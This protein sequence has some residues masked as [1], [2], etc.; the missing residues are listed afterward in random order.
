MCPFLLQDVNFSRLMDGWSCQC[1]WHFWY[2]PGRALEWFRFQKSQTCELPLLIPPVDSAGQQEP[3]SDHQRLPA[4]PKLTGLLLI[5]KVDNSHSVQL[6][7]FYGI[8]EKV[9][10]RPWGDSFARI[11]THCSQNCHQHHETLLDFLFVLRKERLG[12]F[13]IFFFNFFLSAQRKDDSTNTY[14]SFEQKSGIYLF[15]H[16]LL[17]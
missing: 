16:L 13:F 9:W 7:K 1:C 10:S 11:S 17:V 14:N 8:D 2:M 3:S 6:S 15:F 4:F 5:D 12:R